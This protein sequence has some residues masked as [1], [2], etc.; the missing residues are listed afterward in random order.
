M[1]TIHR[2]KQVP[3]EPARMYDL[4]NGIEDYPEFLPWCQASHII[5]RDED[6]VR[7]TLDLSHGPLHK[8]F[9]TCNRLQKNKMIEVRLLEGPF[10]HLEG[11]WRFEP[12]EDN[13]CNIEFDLEFELAGHFLDFAFG[14]V[15]QQV[16]NNLVD[17]F[18]ERAHKIYA[19]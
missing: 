10:K 9:S 18:C 7:A 12:L 16:S 6:E 3:F 2:E 14:P 19:K 1:T 17:L 8:S 13:G 5:S 4:V 11:F 15:F